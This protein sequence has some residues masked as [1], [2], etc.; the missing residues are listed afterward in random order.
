MYDD[1][2][3]LVRVETLFDGLGV[4]FHGVGAS[5]GSWFPAQQSS[6][7]I[8]SGRQHRQPY[9]MEEIG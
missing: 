9:L 1:S 4:T 5:A 2:G 7:C 6:R 8:P 3:I